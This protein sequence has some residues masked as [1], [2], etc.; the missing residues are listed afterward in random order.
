MRPIGSPSEFTSVSGSSSGWSSS[1]SPL[2]G[3]AATRTAV[4]FTSQFT[5]M[6][7]AREPLVKDTGDRLSPWK[8]QN[9]ETKRNLSC[10]SFV[11]AHNVR[12]VMARC[13]S[14]VNLLIVVAV[15]SPRSIRL[16]VSLTT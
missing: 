11:I 9:L 16:V 6:D 12:V 8:S 1:P 3:G 2:S 14:V 10:E 13:R 7:L 15:W 5:R 4:F